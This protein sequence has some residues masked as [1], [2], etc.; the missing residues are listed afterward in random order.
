MT[1]NSRQHQC[2]SC[3]QFRN[4]AAYLETVFRGLTSLGSGYGSVRSDDGICRRHDRYLSARSSCSE[5]DPLT[6]TSTF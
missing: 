3:S 4:D 6:P 1:D 2:R 5:F